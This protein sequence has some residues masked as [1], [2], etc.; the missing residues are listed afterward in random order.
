M[1]ILFTDEMNRRRAAQAIDVL[2]APRLW[3]PT[4]D[5]YG[6]KAHENW[7]AKI[8]HEL[9][10]G[11]RCAP[12]AQSGRS[13]V[14]AIVWRTGEDV[15]QFDIRNISIHPDTRGRSFASLMMRQ[16]E[17]TVCEQAASDTP[18]ITVDTKVTN[19]EM[20]G[21][22][23]SIGYEITEISDLYDSGKLDAILIKHCTRAND[24]RMTN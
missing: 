13:H 19:T 9:V 3:I 12:L 17:H 22:L 18:I 24:V 2:R 14:G 8:E 4:S 1:N 11:K 16:V 21:F 7:L 5:D 15:N 6:M 10:E 23:R 20:I